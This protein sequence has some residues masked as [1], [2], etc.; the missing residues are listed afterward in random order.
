MRLMQTPG[1]SVDD[2]LAEHGLIERQTC[3]WM[4]PRDEVAAA[5]HPLGLFVGWVEASWP[6]PGIPVMVL[7]AVRHVPHS[8]RQAAELRQALESARQSRANAVRTCIYCEI[9]YTPGHMHTD[10]VCQGCAER[11]LG[12]V[13]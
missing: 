9:A 3:L 12:V 10:D 8:Q 2:L 11:H 1:D 4:D 13:H 6:H 5:T 7:K